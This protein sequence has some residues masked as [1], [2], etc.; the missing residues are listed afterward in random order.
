MGLNYKKMTNFNLL[1][2]DKNFAKKHASKRIDVYN[3][4]MENFF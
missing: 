1:T 2:I 3:D 4:S